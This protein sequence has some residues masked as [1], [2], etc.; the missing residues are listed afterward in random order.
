M[1]SFS[2]QWC[3]E[4]NNSQYSFHTFNFPLFKL[5]HQTLHSQTIMHFCQ[6]T[7]NSQ[8]GGTE[9]LSRELPYFGSRGRCFTY[10]LTLWAVGLSSDSD[11]LCSPLYSTPLW[12]VYPPERVLRRDVGDQKM[13]LYVLLRHLAEPIKVQQIQPVQRLF[14]LTFWIDP[15]IWRPQFSLQSVLWRWIYPVWNAVMDC[16]LIKWQK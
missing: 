14:I 16:A 4:K 3:T 15:S 5:S 2:D 12:R 11:G 1:S 7:D 9:A 8:A 10:C 6:I 13:Y